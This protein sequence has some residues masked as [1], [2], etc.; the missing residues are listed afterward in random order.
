MQRLDLAAPRAERRPSKRPADGSSR[1]CERDE[2]GASLAQLGSTPQVVVSV[3]CL[4][5]QELQPRRTWAQSLKLGLQG[6][7]DRPRPSWR[8]SRPRHA[9]ARAREQTSARG[10]LSPSP[11]GCF[12]C[13]GKCHQWFVQPMFWRDKRQQ[14][15]P[16]AHRQRSR[17]WDP[18][19]RHVQRSMR[20][21]CV[22][23]RCSER[24]RCASM[25]LVSTST[26]HHTSC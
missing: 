7:S 9:R 6:G 12:S 26:Q 13:I 19:Q 15:M 1:D 16:H 25:T 24:R 21:S 3:R 18:N 22:M 17:V 5:F 23:A 20:L 4:Q 11:A 2:I 14:D 8:W 10:W